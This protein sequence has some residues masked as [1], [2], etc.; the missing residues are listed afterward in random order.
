MPLRGKTAVVTGGAKGIGRAIA[1]RL[2]KDGANIGILDIQKDKA[3]KTAEEIK[4]AYRRSAMISHPD[5]NPDTPDIEQKFDEM[6]RAYRILLDY[7]RASNQAE[8]A[9]GC[10]FSEEVFEK[11][12]MLVTTVG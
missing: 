1:L 12:A 8:E 3:D 4:K 11:N 9:D 5:K 10:Y 7:H 6:A 2:A